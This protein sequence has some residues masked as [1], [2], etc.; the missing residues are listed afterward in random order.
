MRNKTK[1]IVKVV[2]KKTNEL[3]NVVFTDTRREARVIK[4]GLKTVVG[5][6]R[7]ITIGKA[8]VSPNHAF[9]TESGEFR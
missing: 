4:K 7:N 1:W 2:D 3:K 8:R 5:L 6:V 9:Y